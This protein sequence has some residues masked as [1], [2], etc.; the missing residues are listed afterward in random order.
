MLASILR[1][2][3]KVKIYSEEALKQYN[4][5]DAEVQKLANLTKMGWDL[6]TVDAYNLEM[7]VQLIEGI[8]IGAG[9]V[10]LIVYTVYKNKQKS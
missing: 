10:G 6:C 7:R 1:K 8:L 9:T 5:I 4:F 2:Y 3:G